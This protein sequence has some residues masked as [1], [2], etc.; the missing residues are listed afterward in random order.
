MSVECGM[1]PMTFGLDTRGAWNHLKWRETRTGLPPRVYQLFAVALLTPTL[2]LGGT[3]GCAR[4]DSGG[5]RPV[6]IEEYVDPT[7]GDGIDGGFPQIRYTRTCGY[8][9]G[10]TGEVW[11]AEAPQSGRCPDTPP[12]GA[13]EGMKPY[14]MHPDQSVTDVTD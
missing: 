1:H 9:G 3:V 11:T 7:P 10:H 8:R 12:E 5:E 14:P 13:P 4:I 6:P 2:F